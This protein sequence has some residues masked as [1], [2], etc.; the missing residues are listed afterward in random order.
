MLYLFQG[1]AI[2]ILAITQIILTKGLSQLRDH[3][4]IIRND[5]FYIKEDIKK[6]KKRMDNAEEDIQCL[7]RNLG[8]FM[9]DKKI[10]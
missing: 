3:V 1:I 2:I 9:G 4:G 6:L 5:Q 7:S 8:R 10:Q